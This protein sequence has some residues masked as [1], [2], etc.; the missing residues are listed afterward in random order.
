MTTWI[1][2]IQP[3]H[4]VVLYEVVAAAAGV[5]PYGPARRTFQGYRLPIEVNV[6]SARMDGQNRQIATTTRTAKVNGPMLVADPKFVGFDCVELRQYLYEDGTEFHWC[7]PTIQ[8]ALVI[9]GV[10]S[11]NLWRNETDSETYCSVRRRH[12]IT[13]SDAANAFTSG[14]WTLR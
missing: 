6:P 7:I 10:S 2:P 11:R 9:R 5:C 14:S 8:F 4:I 13:A 1:D 3:D 12:S